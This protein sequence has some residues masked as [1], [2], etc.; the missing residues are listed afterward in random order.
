MNQELNIPIRF[1]GRV[2]LN[3]KNRKWEIKALRFYPLTGSLC[4]AGGWVINVLNSRKNAK[5]WAEENGY[6]V[7]R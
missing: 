5:E 7:I 4:E 1:D 6:T 2:A 3:N